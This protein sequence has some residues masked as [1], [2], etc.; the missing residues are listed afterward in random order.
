MIDTPQIIQTETQLTASI[1][2]VVPKSQIREVMGP[3]L[4]EIM[5]ALKAQGITPTGPW[6]T[7][8]FRMDPKVFDYEICVPVPTPVKPVGR[9]KPGQLS[10]RKIARTLYHG[11]YE[12]LGD[13]WGEFM[14]WIESNGHTKAEDLWEQYLVSYDSESDENKFCTQLNCPLV[15]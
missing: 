6:L 3:G 9:V 11:P 10:A 4:Q 2:L 1:Q 12:G 14:D 13:A 15:Q 8:H 5:A 7:H